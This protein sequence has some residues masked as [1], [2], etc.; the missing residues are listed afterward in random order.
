MRRLSLV[1][2]RH[3]GMLLSKKRGGK[4]DGTAIVREG[5]AVNWHSYVRGCWCRNGWT[6][7]KLSAGTSTPEELVTEQN[8]G[9]CIIGE[10]NMAKLDRQT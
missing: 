2:C 5:S 8:I 9:G 4:L 6:R 7:G 3:T 10:N 1:L